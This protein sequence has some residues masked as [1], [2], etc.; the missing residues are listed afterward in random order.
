[1][2]TLEFGSIITKAAGSIGGTTFAKTRAGYIA[3]N[4]PAPP[5]PAG[6]LQL[7]QQTR[8]KLAAAL[9]RTLP[10]TTQ[11]GWNDY[12]DSVT[13]TNRLGQAFTPTGQQMFIRN[14]VFQLTTGTS[15]SLTEPPGNLGIPSWPQGLLGLEN[16]DDL[17]VEDWSAG[18]AG[19]FTAL[20]R[21]YL[22]QLQPSGI[23]RRLWDSFVLT[24]GSPLPFV[25]GS[26]YF[27]NAP[28]GVRL[29]V[30]YTQSIMD[31][32][33]RVTNPVTYHFSIT[34]P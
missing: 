8:L 7:A 25:L 15:V 21:I 13:L 20:F 18:V 10:V 19:E 5:L 30:P 14:A 32:S 9:W 22:W 28:T 12:A 3:K 26:H 17:A 2:A 4:R 11:D 27:A 24:D 33:Q 34:L 1:M 23:Q 16:T 31:A 6:A 29:F